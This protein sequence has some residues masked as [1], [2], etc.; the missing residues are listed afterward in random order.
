MRIARG[1]DQHHGGC[2]NEFQLQRDGYV[3]AFKSST[4][5]N[6]IVNTS[7][8]RLGRIAA[9]LIYWS[10]ASQQAVAV[11]WT[12]L[13]SVANINS[14]A[15][16][17][18]AAARPFSGGT[19]IYGAINF[20]FPRFDTNDYNGTSQVIDVSG[21]GTSSAS[22]TAA[23]RDAALAAGIDRINGL[24]IGGSSSLDNFYSTNVIGGTGSFLISASTFSDFSG[25]VQKKLALEITGG[26]PS[27][28]PLP[29]AAW[30]LGGAV[31]GFGV[32]RRR[33]RG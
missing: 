18:G 8:N 9:E 16:A 25:A 28:V 4:V 17:I 20:G 33:R 6:A 32:M 23:S 29:A 1:R 3:N 31:A 21:D 11:G 10:S 13:D 24:T 30:L 7:N 27:P 14:F 12:L 22:L 5:Q 19:A 15:D 2:R 26:E